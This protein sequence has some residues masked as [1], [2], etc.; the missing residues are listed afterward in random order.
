MSPQKQIYVKKEDLPLWEAAEK[1]GS[2]MS[3]TIMDALRSFVDAKAAA[4]Q[5]MSEHT[6]KTSNE[7]ESSKKR[8]IGRLIAEKFYSPNE[9]ETYEWAVYQ[10]RRGFLVWGQW[11]GSALGRPITADF[12]TG[13]TIAAL[14]DVEISDVV[15]KIPN[16]L[17]DTAAD[18]IGEPIDMLDI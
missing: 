5:G 11:D 6:V 3:G 1:Y 18:E 4:E 10:C 2:S 14:R 16:D 8:F 12:V 9:H 7:W 17:L 15:G 13:K